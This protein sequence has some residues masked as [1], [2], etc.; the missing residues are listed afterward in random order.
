ME[1]RGYVLHEVVGDGRTGRVYRA[2][3]GDGGPSVAFRQLRPDLAR[4]PGVPEAI[5]ALVDDCKPL[6]HAAI[7]P[8]TDAFSVEGAICVV[9]TW[10]EGKSLK[11]RLGSGTLPPDEVATLGVE[12]AEALMELHEAGLVHG[13]VSPANI[14]LT[15]RGSRLGGVGVADRSGRRGQARSMFGDPY[16]APELQNNSKASPSTDLFGLATSLEFALKGEQTTGTFS[17]AEEEPDALNRVLRQ[18]AS[19]HPSMRFDD[20]KE[21]R[22]AL[23]RILRDSPPSGASRQPKPRMETSELELGDVEGEEPGAKPGRMKM[24]PRAAVAEPAGPRLELPPWWPKALAGLVAIVALVGLFRFL[25]SLLPDVPDG[26]VEIPEGAAGLGDAQGTLDERPGYRWS[27]PR[28]FLD[29]AEVTLGAYQSCV[30]EGGCTPVGSRLERMQQDPDEPVAGITWLQANAFCLSRGKRLPSENEWEAAARH[31][32]GHYPWGN[33]EPHCGLAWY[34]RWLTGACGGPDVVPVVRIVDPERL[35]SA[36]GPLDLAGNL[37]EFTNSD[38]EPH[39]RSGTGTLA[40]AGSSVLKVIKGG[41]YSTGPEELR[42][43]AR[44]GVEMDHWAA[45]VGFRCAADPQK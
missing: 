1:I 42:S 36:Q 18:G 31:F 20:A 38:Y 40:P 17:L 37:W 24:A 3:Q 2:E 41:A 32:G 7:V 16:D 21:F 33:K 12:L 26:M 34:G 28:F 19:S 29:R 43:A 39:R 45:D 15:S 11:E 5:I 6:E 23:L 14:Y 13:D 25:V 35:E 27:H 9:E 30:G 44:L 8:V 4:E 10:I 22:K